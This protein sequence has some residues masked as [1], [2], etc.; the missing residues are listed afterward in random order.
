[1][2]SRREKKKE[3]KKERK[4]TCEADSELVNIFSNSK[5][6]RSK[7]GG[8][9]ARERTSIKKERKK[10]AAAFPLWEGK[11]GREGRGRRM[12]KKERERERREGEGEGR[13]TLGLEVGLE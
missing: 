2:E 5:T 13:G 8:E 11:E 3:R 1:M 10:E 9:E 4:K 6:Q 12:R 7:R